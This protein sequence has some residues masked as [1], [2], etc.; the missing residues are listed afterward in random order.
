MKRSLASLTLLPLLAVLPGCVAAIG[1]TGYAGHYTKGAR[2]LLEQRVASASRIVELRQQH[3]D[4]L[5]VQQAA[6]KVE[7]RTVI[8][9]EIALEEARMVLLDCKA[10]LES[11]GKKD[12]DDD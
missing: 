1:N 5:R 12:R 10:Q 7:T 2:P 6:G 8:E 9:A 4:G 3:L 11:T